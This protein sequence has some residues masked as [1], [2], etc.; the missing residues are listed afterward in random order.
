MLIALLRVFLFP[1][2]IWLT[3]KD[4]AKGLS[5]RRALG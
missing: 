2:V 5:K 3:D 1:E 4:A